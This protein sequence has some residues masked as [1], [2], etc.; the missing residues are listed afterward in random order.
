[1]SAH[2]GSSHFDSSHYDSSHYGPEI[3]I[4]IPGGGGPEIG[5]IE[6]LTNDDE[7]IL[8]VIKKFLEM[9]E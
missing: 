3:V 1:M 4:E 5:P 6:D 7:V 8:A 9:M 2:F